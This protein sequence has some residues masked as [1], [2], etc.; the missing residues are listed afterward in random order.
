MEVSINPD[1]IAHSLNFH[2]QQLQKLWEGERGED[3]LLKLNVDSKVL[4]FEVYQQR[5][6]HLRFV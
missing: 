2:G 5:S 3:D 1:L 4:D 6:K